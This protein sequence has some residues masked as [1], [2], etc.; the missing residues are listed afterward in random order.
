MKYSFQTFIL[1]HN[2]PDVIL[3]RVLPYV[4]NKR[5]TRIDNVIANRLTG[6]QLAIECPDDI[7]NVFAAMRTAEALGIGN[8]H[9]ITPEGTAKQANTVSRGASFWGEAHFYKDLTNFLAT[10]KKHRLILAG[11]TLDGDISVDALPIEQPLCIFLG[12]EQRC[13]TPAAQSIS[14]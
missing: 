6:I 13:L 4:G 11:G 5:Q 9:I 8:I 7:N 1:E 2:S 12:N 10:A 14:L 3:G